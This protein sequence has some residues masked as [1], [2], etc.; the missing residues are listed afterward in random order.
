MKTAGIACRVL[1]LVSAFFSRRKT[2]DGE[3]AEEQRRRYLRAMSTV[4]EIEAAIEQLPTRQMLEVAG[5]T[6]AA[7]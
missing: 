3:V 7:E 6:S 4:A 5:W 2:A 1:A